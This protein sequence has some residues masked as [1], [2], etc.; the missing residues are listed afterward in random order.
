MDEARGDEFVE[1]LMMEVDLDNALSALETRL[2]W[3]LF[4]T[5]VATIGVIVPVL[6]LA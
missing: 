1:R 3:R 6:K 4:V 5:A 2:A